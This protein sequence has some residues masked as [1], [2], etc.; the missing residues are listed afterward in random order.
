M[1]KV[2]KEIISIE[3][4]TKWNEI[5]RLFKNID[6][7]YNYNYVKAFCNEE[8]TDGFM[9]YYNDGNTKAINVFTKIKIEENDNVKN[10]NTNKKDKI[11]YDIISP[12]GYGGFIIEGNNFENVN[13]EFINYCKEKNITNE[14]VRF[15]LFSSYKDKYYGKTE[16]VKKNVVRRINGTP[17]ELL[18]DFEYKIRKNLKR[19]KENNLEIV[20]DNNSQ[21]LQEFISIYYN[22]MR[23]NGAKQKYYFSEKFFQEILKMKN[24]SLIFFVKYKQEFI[25]TELVLY[26]KNN[27]YSFLGGTNSEYFKYRPNDFLKFEIIK[28]AYSKGLKNF[29]LGGGYTNEI[30]DGILKYK[31]SFAPNDEFVDFYIGKARF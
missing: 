15:S 24:N 20:I 9:F 16:A 7:F 23:R 10:T 5:I 21:Y 26:D 2:I 22:T 25:S 17:N 4:E 6:V 27:C 14:I 1:Q 19:A 3:N 30:D 18:Q 13:K 11:T 29:V 12:Y 8:S 28:W 31:K